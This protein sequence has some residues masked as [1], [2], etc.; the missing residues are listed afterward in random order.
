MLEVVH[1]PSYY[2]IIST[3]HNRFIPDFASPRQA[4]HVILIVP[5]GKDTIPLECTSSELPFG[6]VHSEIAGHDALLVT[7]EGGKIY[8]LPTYPDS[9][10]FTH[11]L[12]RIH[13]DNSGSM[14]AKV[15]FIYTLAHYEEM[16]AFEKIANNDDRIKI[17]KA[18]YRLLSMQISNIGVIEKHDSLPAITLNYTLLSDMYANQSGTRLF[19]PVNPR[20]N[21]YPLLSRKERMYPFV[22]NSGTVECDTIIITIP[23]GM[24]VEKVPSDVVLKKMFGSFSSHLSMRGKTLQIIQRIDIP[25]EEFPASNN[26]DFKFFMNEINQAYEGQI[27]LKKL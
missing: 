10:S 8:R 14:Q 23:D 1:I 9:A 13:L 12:V 4:N 5:L 19:V 17:I 16:I 6:Y 21:K 7:S 2:A 11:T 15:R 27:V 26:E 22:I 18:D 24:K 3:Y 20:R 25:K